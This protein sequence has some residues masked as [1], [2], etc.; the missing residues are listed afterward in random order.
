MRFNRHCVHTDKVKQA[1][2]KCSDPCAGQC[3]LGGHTQLNACVG[4]A[5][6]CKKARKTKVDE[7]HE[8]KTLKGTRATKGHTEET[9]ELKQRKNGAS[10][11][12]PKAPRVTVQGL[13]DDGLSDGG[14]SEA[15]EWCSFFTIH[16]LGSP[17]LSNFSVVRLNFFDHFTQNFAPHTRKKFILCTQFRRSVAD[18]NYF[19][20]HGFFALHE[21]KLL[22]AR[23]SVFFT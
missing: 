8:K 10:T 20:G 2:T 11:K 21:M 17:H 18:T 12:E 7:C 13:F 19:F 23:F 6:A 14:E 22:I 15:S 4:C 9:W 3:R 1:L 5:N 16:L